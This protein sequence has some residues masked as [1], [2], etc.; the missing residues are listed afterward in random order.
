[1]L[2]VCITCS[3]I[4]ASLYSSEGVSLLRS[5]R[6]NGYAALPKVIGTVVGS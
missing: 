1:M 3:E 5:T 4:Y 2:E 6:C